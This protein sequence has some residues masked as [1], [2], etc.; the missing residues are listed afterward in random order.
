[1][2]LGAACE[3]CTDRR[4][5]VLK[6]VELHGAWMTFCHNCS[7]R[8]FKLEPMPSS[9]AEIK[10]RLNRERRNE[11]RRTDS[12]D[13][14]VFQYDRRQEKRR[15]KRDEESE[16]NST[17]LLGVDLALSQKADP[18]QDLTCISAE[19]LAENV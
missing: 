10:K 19:A 6:S 13:Q 3:A 17:P 1:M 9:V 12:E 5:E 11:E 14:R 2:G 7:A 15:S 8:I 18:K 16:E 4:I